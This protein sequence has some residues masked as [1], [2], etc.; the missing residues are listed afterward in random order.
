MLSEKT[1]VASSKLETIYFKKQNWLRAKDFGLFH[2]LSNKGDFIEKGQ[3]LHK[4]QI[5]KSYFGCTI[6]ANYALIVFQGELL[7]LF[8]PSKHLDLGG[9][10][11]I[12]KKNYEKKRTQ[13]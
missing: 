2:H 11:L 1:E 9:Q 13:N 12:L 10:K 4:L 8:L 3:V 7:I 5:K 6:N